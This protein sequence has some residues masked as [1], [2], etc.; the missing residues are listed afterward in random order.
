MRQPQPQPSRPEGA[1]HQ[2]QFVAASMETSLADQTWSVSLRAGPVYRAFFL[3]RGRAF[4]AAPDRAPI[5]LAGP[6]ILW[7]P[8]TASGSFRL[9]AGGD[10]AT[11][12]AREE[13]IRRAANE[14][15]LAARLRP[16]ID[17][18]LI[19]PAARIGPDVREIEAIFA[20]LGRESRDPG[21]GAAAMN[22]LY[23]GLILAHLWRACGISGAADS[24]VTG[25]PIAERF[26]QLVELHYRDNL[27]VDDYAHDL[28]VTRAQ[29][30]ASCVRALGL[31]PL[32]LVHVR[33]MAEARLR[34][35]ETAQPVEQIG[36]GLG[37][38]D[39]SYFNRFFR[40][41]SGL[42]PGAYRKAS[43]ID[44]PREATSFAAWP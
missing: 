12:T 23:L 43:R 2:G 44:P 16:L 32:K 34:L 5:E 10:G 20:A 42:A 30:H 35:R 26:R 28:G 17:R 7:L 29:L 39:P 33:L 6:Q 3:R 27:S 14:S 24:F 15:S 31:A 37:F 22:V 38:R 40:R 18:E 8:T 11:L 9:I 21:P 4:F 13:I 1:H 36:Y 19:V 25:A 41:L